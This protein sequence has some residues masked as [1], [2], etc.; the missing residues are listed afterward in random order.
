MAIINVPIRATIEFG[1]LIIK[2][3][4]IL[5]FNVSKTRNSK[6]TFS[7][8][9]KVLAIDLTHMEN[10]TIVIYAGE[11]NNEIKI[12]TGYILSTRPTIC[13]DDPNFTV[14]NLSGSDALFLLEGEKYT[15]RTIHSK[16]KWAII[17]SVV[18]KAGKSQKFELNYQPLQTVDEDLISSDEKKSKSNNTQDLN[19]IGNTNLPTGVKAFNFNFS[20]VKLVGE[21]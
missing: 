4:Y 11:K 17:D 19:S 6:S 15:R 10:N 20:E 16:R 8:S 13:F 21:E 5:S 1:G 7:A 18:R 9:L 3:P 12:F 2:T 14:L